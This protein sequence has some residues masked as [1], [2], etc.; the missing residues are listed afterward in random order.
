MRL[1][2][3]RAALLTAARVGLAIIAMALLTFGALGSPD[4]QA[5]GMMLAAAFMYAWQ[6]VLSQRIMY[7][8]PAPP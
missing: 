1:A 3:H 7:D 4:W 8:M 5:V 6:L 2:G